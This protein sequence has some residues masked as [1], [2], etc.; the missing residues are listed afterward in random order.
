MHYISDLVSHLNDYLQIALFTDYCPNGLQVEG[1][2]EVKRVA[3]AVSASEKVIQEAIEKKADLLIVHHGLFWNKDSYV[4]TG[5]K[6]RKLKLL[7]ESG[8]NL[9]AYHLPLDAHQEV[10]NNWKAARDLG[11]NDLQPFCSIGV[12]GK[13]H[14]QSRE[15]F[16]ATLEAYYGQKA[17]VVWGGKD[18]IASCALIS[19]GAYR[20]V[21][22]ASKAG[23]DAFITGNFD[24]PAWHMAHEEKINFLAQGHAATEK[25]GP[26]AL[27]EYI[28]STFEL[29][30]F[31]ID[32]ANPF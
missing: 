11:W 31:F 23:V 4:V 5:P 29:E 18:K 28:Q 15:G 19:G 12:Q 3:T 21:E 26:K 7:L 24:E 13:V 6:M 25:V 32:E 14:P 27:G 8:L 9:A 16:Q 17:A 10:G 20:S 30:T 1:K 2:H 22:D